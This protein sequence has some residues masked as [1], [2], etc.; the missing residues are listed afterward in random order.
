MCGIAGLVCVDGQSIRDRLAKMNDH[1]GHRGPDDQGIWL[2]DNP[3][4][5]IGLAHRRLSIID[6]S[7]TGHQPMELPDNSGVIVFNGEIYNYQELRTDLEKQ[8]IRLRGHSDTEVLLWGLKLYSTDFLK[9]LRGM[10]AFGYYDRDKS[11]L[12]LARDPSGI[13]PLYYYRREDEFSF[14]SE[15]R[16]LVASGSVSKKLS[17]SALGGFLAYGA[18]PQPLTILDGVRMLPAGS[19]LRMNT[20]ARTRLMELKTW[21]QLPVPDH[22]QV[23]DVLPRVRSLVEDSVKDHLIA[24][25]P[26]GV[27]LSAG[28]DSTLIASIAKRFNDLVQAFTVDLAGTEGSDE[29]EIAS[30]TAKRIGIAHQIVRVSDESAIEWMQQWLES[31]DQPSID[32][33]NTFIISKAVASCGIKVALAGLGADE[34]FGGYS[35]FREVEGLQ[36]AHKRLTFLPAFL[37]QGIVS[38][39]T[40]RKS[41]E[42]R[43]KLLDMMNSRGGIT[44]LAVLRR[45]L[46]SDRQLRDLGLWTS[47][48]NRSC[49]L[50]EEV[51]TLF[52]SEESP[53]W[54]ISRAEFSIYQQNMLLR[55]SDANSMAHSLEIRVPFLDQRILDWVPTIP[56]NI[57]FPTNESG[58]YLL[59]EACKDYLGQAQLRRPKTGFT[60]PFTQWMAGPLRDTCEKKLK[61]VKAL[62]VLDPNAVQ[63]IWNHF[64]RTRTLASS[65]RALALVSL[66]SAVERFRF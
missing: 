35:T 54:Q 61:T 50:P 51:Q 3:G 41:F 56:D 17:L 37:R 64:M 1:M 7:A 65:T 8:G 52:L 26:V 39:I 19:W 2:N 63:S 60:V 21:W 28:I 34:L 12:L 47:D 59:R 10:Y 27:F 4:I 43:E 57:R 44:R 18:V 24:D 42:A 36:K 40:A 31:T 25:V 20:Q 5:G 23:T 66:G 16:S 49:F 48:L 14:A 38:L 55:D 33:L 6:L 32:G 53:G 15:L 62:G 11:E 13:K 29:A 58:K 9:Q 22:E 45:R 46:L 30:E